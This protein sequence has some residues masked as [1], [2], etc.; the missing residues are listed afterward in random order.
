MGRDVASWCVIDGDL[1][2]YT[3]HAL[4]LR[5]QKVIVNDA[6]HN[7][8]MIGN[9]QVVVLLN[10]SFWERSSVRIEGRI[11]CWG[12]VHCEGEMVENG[13]KECHDSAD[14]SATRDLQR[15]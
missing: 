6:D 12:L 5:D 13:S 1:Y 8:A 2:I 15:P 14:I 7:K 11:I 4:Y 3:H 9:V 10:P